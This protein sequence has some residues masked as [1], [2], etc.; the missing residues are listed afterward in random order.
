MNKLSDSS[1]K[2]M[3]SRIIT[4]VVLCIVGIPPIIL[5]NWYMFVLFFVVSLIVVYEILTAPGKDKY[6]WFL[7]VIV[8]I[9]SIS[10]IYWQF[11]KNDQTFKLIIEN[12]HFTLNTLTVS[13]IGITVFFLLLFLISILDE[14]VT[15]NDVCY[16]FSMIVFVSLSIYSCYFLRYFPEQTIY[17]GRDNLASCLLFFYAMLG[18]FSTDIGAYF[19]GVLFGKH[20]MNPRIS[21]K[22]SL[23]GFFGGVIFSFA[24]SFG[25]AAVCSHLNVPLIPGVLDFQGNNWVWILVISLAMP[26]MSNLGDFLFSAI[27]RSYSIKD[28]G[29]ILPGHG[30]ALDRIDSLLVN[31]LFVSI[32][33]I[34]IANNWNFFI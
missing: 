19:V 30:G 17:Y 29:Y 10:F 2:S 25:F 27:K 24:I 23:E 21:P 9:S 33:V 3:L 13:T 28:F 11:V 8:Y 32:M 14:K 18:A 7:Y 31:N 6:Q 12:A 1:K 15:I 22:K 26:L 16:L 34:M 20:R 4:G 5:G